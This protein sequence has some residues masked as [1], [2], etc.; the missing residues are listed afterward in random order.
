MGRVVLQPRCH[1][2]LGHQYLF[3]LFN[4]SSNSSGVFLNSHVSWFCR[5]SS[6]T[7]QSIPFRLLFTLTQSEQSIGIASVLTHDRFK[8]YFC[9]S[10]LLNPC[11]IYSLTR[12]LSAWSR[13]D[14]RQN[15]WARCFQGGSKAWKQDRLTYLEN[16]PPEQIWLEASPKLRS[17]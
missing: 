7:G 4:C 5:Y 12:D 1:P 17:E 13:A 16:Q 14:N 9:A 15:S 2:C 8:S 10:L 11:L 6:F 3:S